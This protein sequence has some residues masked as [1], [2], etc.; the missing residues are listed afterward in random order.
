ME[1]DLRHDHDDLPSKHGESLV[2]VAQLKEKLARNAGLEKDLYRYREEKEDLLKQVQKVSS[3]LEE[4]VAK[5]QATTRDLPE[6]HDSVK[7]KYG[8]V[9]RDLVELKV[10]LKDEQNLHQES[11]RVLSGG[12]H[13]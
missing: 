11:R 1:R 10:S 13:D 12:V 9:L 8:K 6:E 3:E 5:H 4:E 2:E 7:R